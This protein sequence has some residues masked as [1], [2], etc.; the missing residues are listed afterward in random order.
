MKSIIQKSYENYHKKILEISKK[1]LSDLE[2]V[3]IVS[4]SHKTYQPRFK[5]QKQANIKQINIRS[6]LR[7]IRDI[8][9]ILLSIPGLVKLFF[10]A[11]WTNMVRENVMRMRDDRWDGDACDVIGR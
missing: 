3:A 4:A 9:F 11:N 5:N 7:L 6:I 1:S 2:L 10:S 8:I